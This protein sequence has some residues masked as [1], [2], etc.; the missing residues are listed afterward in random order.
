MAIWQRAAA[1]CI[2]QAR[3]YG[4]PGAL[5]ASMSNRDIT[6]HARLA[7]DMLDGAA[8]SLDLS[9]SAYMRTI[10]VARTIADLA[11]CLDIE[12]PHITEAL[13]YRGRNY[14]TN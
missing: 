3:R 6:R 8:A 14:Q 13:Q 1:V 4:A 9:A 7:T 5:N 10:K 12:Q 2:L 11:S